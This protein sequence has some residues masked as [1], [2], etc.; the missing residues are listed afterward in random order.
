MKKQRFPAGWDEERV[1]QVLAH[2]ETQ[3]D[4]EAAAEDASALRK[5]RQ[6]LVQV[7][8]ELMPVIREILAQHGSASKL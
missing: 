8:T 1:R 6:T 5:S 2:Y 3:T 7:P 4:D